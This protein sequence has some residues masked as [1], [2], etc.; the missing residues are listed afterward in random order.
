VH[1]FVVSPFSHSSL[2]FEQ[3]KALL[4]DGPA[5]I[6]HDD[7]VAHYRAWLVESAVCSTIGP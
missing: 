4:C 6:H 3:H 1:C 2:Y 7:V 5:S